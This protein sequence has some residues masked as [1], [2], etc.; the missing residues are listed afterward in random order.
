MGGSGWAPATPCPGGC[1]EALGKSG[2]KGPPVQLTR[3]LGGSANQAMG[4]PEILGMTPSVPAELDPQGSGLGHL[5]P[6]EATPELP[7]AF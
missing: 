5:L 2:K 3:G 4:F 1:T 7:S 6:P